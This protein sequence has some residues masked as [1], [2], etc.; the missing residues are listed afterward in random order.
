MRLNKFVALALD[1][2][3]RKADQLISD[4]KI[5]INNQTAAFN[6]EPKPTD[7][8]EYNNQLLRVD[9]GPQIILMLNKPTGIVC[10][11]EGQG[12]NTIYDI[13]PRK[14]HSLNPIGRLDKDSSGLLIMTNDGHLH[15]ELSHPSKLKN[16]TYQI[17]INKLL[18]DADRKSINRGI[19]LDDGISRLQLEPWNGSNGRRWIVTMHEGRNRQIRRTFAHLGYKVT[20]LNRIQ[21]GPYELGQL[22]AGHFKL[23]K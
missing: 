8:I 17:V 4:G 19:K 13:I 11:R 18:S 12:S 23:V 9:A 14:Y 3:R 10:S 5:S 15:Q 6:Y 16:K 1:I 2:S 22:D 21:F 7:K 20:Q